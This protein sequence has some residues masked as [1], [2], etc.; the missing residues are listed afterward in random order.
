MG[1]E[2]AE[3]AAPFLRFPEQTR[4]AIQLAVRLHQEAYSPPGAT[5]GMER[6]G[7]GGSLAGRLNGLDGLVKRAVLTTVRGVWVVGRGGRILGAC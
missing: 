3:V 2:G 6:K 1:G 5:P 4:D 7:G